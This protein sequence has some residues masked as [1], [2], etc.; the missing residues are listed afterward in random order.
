M[1]ATA[2][3]RLRQ[4]P[5]KS[6]SS[7]P[8]HRTSGC[9]S[10]TA[11]S[12]SPRRTHHG[13]FRARRHWMAPSLRIPAPTL[14]GQASEAGPRGP[15]WPRQPGGGVLRQALPLTGRLPSSSTVLRRSRGRRSPPRR[16]SFKPS[17]TSRFARGTAA[18]PLPSASRCSR[19][20]SGWGDGSTSHLQS[21]GDRHRRSA[22]TCMRGSQCAS[23][24]CWLTE[25]PAAD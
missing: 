14:R 21:R 4:E 17:S 5:S 24:R 7:P 23:V 22:A 8:Y 10:A 25:A 3:P 13:H 9:S 12:R 18:V 15:A 1:N 11:A 2:P 6:G 16:R 19:R 20:S